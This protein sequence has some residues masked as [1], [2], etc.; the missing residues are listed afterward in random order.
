MSIDISTLKVS[1]MPALAIVYAQCFAEAPWNEVFAVDELVAEFSEIASWDDSVLVV[2]KCGGQIVGGSIGFSMKRKDDICALLQDGNDAFYLAELFVAKPFRCS[3][4]ATA[5]VRARAKHAKKLGFTKA[6]VRTSVDQTIIRRLYAGMG[7]RVV[8]EQVVESL[9][10]V[11]GV[12]VM[13]T[14]VRV[15]IQ[16]TL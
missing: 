1:D 15:L 9:K 2:A 14:D 3:G 5:L 12:P 7:F 4:V 13:A 6:V 10:N 8:A 16:G 11:N